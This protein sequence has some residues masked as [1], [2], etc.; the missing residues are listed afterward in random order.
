[1]SK[2]EEIKLVLELMRMR[3]LTAIEAAQE[4]NVIKRELY[5]QGFLS[6]LVG[7][8]RKA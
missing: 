6:R 3:G 5:P 8:G 4:I 1:M 2:A 7:I